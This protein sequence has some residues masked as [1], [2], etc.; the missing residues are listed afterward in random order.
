VSLVDDL[1]TRCTFPPSGTE[2]DCAVSGGPDST[3]LLVLACAAGC[4]ATAIHVDHGIREGSTAE[5]DV[6]ADLAASLGAEFRSARVVVEPGPNLE[7]RARRARYDVLPD[8][9]LT[10]H[11][12]DDQAETVLLNLMRGSALDGLAGMRPERR[13]LLRLRRRETVALCAEE[14]LVTVDDPSN[15]DPAFRRNR[16]RHEL[17]PLLD[18]IAG[19]DV[20]ALLARQADLMREGADHVVA[21]SRTIDVTDA[22]ALSDAPMP[23]ARVAVRRWI[24]AETDL[25]H[26]V[27]A[28]A[29]GRVLD[30]ARMDAR[31][32]DVT[33]GWRVE[34]TGGRLRLTRE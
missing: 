12:A 27:D 24:A 7:A 28:A 14:G 16:V 2:V 31:A 26:P 30:V 19:R 13:P 25:G 9:V 5:A 32:A 17:L 23:L 21:A 8:G 4:R 20:A 6:V 18:D 1:L 34:R 10:G 15:R 22:R 11:T 29:V 33:D 3:A